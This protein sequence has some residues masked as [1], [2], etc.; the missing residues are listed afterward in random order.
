MPQD[1]F[2]VDATQPTDVRRASNQERDITMTR[3]QVINRPP[4]HLTPL[5]VNR[6]STM[7]INASAD[8]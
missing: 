2:H 5:S 4:L 8:W 1:T 6:Q 7:Q 3:V